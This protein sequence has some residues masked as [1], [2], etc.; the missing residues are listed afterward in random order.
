MEKKIKAIIQQAID[1]TMS[2]REIYLTM[3]DLVE[4]PRNQGDFAIPELRMKRVIRGFCKR[5]LDEAV[6]SGVPREEITLRI[7]E[8]AAPSPKNVPKEALVLAIK[9]EETLHKFY[10]YLEN[11]NHRAIPFCGRSEP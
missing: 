10:K 2:S 8:N 4:R 11:A 9:R 7:P 5:I 6:A 3:A 1:L